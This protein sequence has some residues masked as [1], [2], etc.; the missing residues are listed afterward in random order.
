MATIG[1]LL[2][3]EQRARSGQSYR[4]E[5]VQLHGL[6]LQ[7]N[8]NITNLTWLE[9]VELSATDGLPTNV[10]LLAS[11]RKQKSHWHMQQNDAVTDQNLW[12]RI[13]T[14]VGQHIRL[15]NTDPSA[16]GSLNGTI[17]QIEDALTQQ[18]WTTLSESADMLLRQ[19]A[20]DKAPASA[21]T[22]VT[23]ARKRIAAEHALQESWVRLLSTQ[24]THS[25]SPMKLRLKYIIPLLLGGAAL[26]WLSLQE[27]HVEFQLGHYMLEMSPLALGCYS[28]ARP[29]ADDQAGSIA[30]LGEIPSRT[31]ETEQAQ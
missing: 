23:Q 20:N 10:E 2:R 5:W 16:N 8:H 24:P 28:L 21:I 18:N 13:T 31:H 17:Q 1:A 29:M 3:L 26:A 19:L 6:W 25:P 4:A 9:P 7:L 15:H 11:L 14:W 27:G 30:R 12:N 22:W